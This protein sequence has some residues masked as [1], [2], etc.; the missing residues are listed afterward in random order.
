MQG[1]LFAKLIGGLALAGVVFAGP[2][3]AQQLAQTSTEP[4]VIDTPPV[5]LPAELEEG[6][7]PA[8]EAPDLEVVEGADQIVATL[9]EITFSGIGVLD[10]ADAQ[11]AAA[12][13]IGRPVTRGD[14]AQLKFDITKLYYDAGYILVRVTTPPQDLSDGILEIVVIEARIGSIEVTNEDTI[15]PY[16]ARALTGQVRVGDVFREQDVESM[17]S[18]VNDLGNVVA[19]LNLR[20]GAEVGTTDMA[21]TISPAAEDVQRITFDNYGSEVTEEK[22]SAIG[23]TKSNLFGLGETLSLDAR[24][25][26][27]DDLHSLAF[28]GEMPIGWRNLK[29]DVRYTK[30]KIQVDSVGTNGASDVFNIALSSAILNQ[31]RQ[32]FVVRGGFEAREHQTTGVAFN[33][34]DIRRLFLSGSYLTRF[35]R[36]VVFA[37]LE[38]SKGVKLFGASDEGD[39]DASRVSG[40]PTV[41]RLAPFLF[42]SYQVSDQDTLR[43]TVSGQWASSTTLASDLFALGGFGSM[44]GF[45]SAQTTGEAGYRFAL[46][47]SHRFMIGIPWLTMQ[48]GPFFEAGAVFN[49]NDPSGILDDHLYDAGLTVEFDFAANQFDSRAPATNT[50][51]RLD[52]AWRLGHYR[53]TGLDGARIDSNTILVRLSQTF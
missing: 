39:A 19:T 4:G 25:D 22:V 46:E 27:E 11:A 29:L 8:P 7:A 2:S 3:G 32:R 50:N 35:P 42:T 20:P 10:E 34:D 13:Y 24:I 6:G 48:A 28:A 26:T 33:N 17:I 36:T 18:D 38:I 14:L 1:H 12:S 51:L 5:E 9:S 37:S 21:I 44:R 16:L 40:K 45:E 23:L 30:S 53:S 31:R 43:A 47:Y 52:W 49:R 41:W 15:Q